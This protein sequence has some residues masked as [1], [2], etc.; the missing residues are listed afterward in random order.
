[1]QPMPRNDIEQIVDGQCPQLVAP[2]DQLPPD[3]RESTCGIL[4]VPL[5]RPIRPQRGSPRR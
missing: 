1:M 5:R 2:D 4:A 3:V